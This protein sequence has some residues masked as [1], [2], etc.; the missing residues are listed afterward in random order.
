[1]YLTQDR[2]INTELY[3]EK[4]NDMIAQ[5]AE[6]MIQNPERKT[7]KNIDDYFYL[8][9][10]AHHESRF[11]MDENHYKKWNHIIK[12]AE[13]VLAKARIFDV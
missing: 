9:S 12:E 7:N 8:L 1:M 10:R 11:Y 5:Y 6:F 13:Y 3:T 2:I 4:L